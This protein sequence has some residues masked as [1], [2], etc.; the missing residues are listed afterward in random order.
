VPSRR[1]R[2]PS[3]ERASDGGSYDL[4]TR[5]RILV[6]GNST[7]IRVIPRRTSRAQGLYSERLERRLRARGIDVEVRN[8]GYAWHRV[9][10]VLPRQFPSLAHYCPDVVILNYGAG[11]A[12]PNFPPT[13]FMRWHT[14]WNSMPPLG[15]VTGRLYRAFQAPIGKAISR[16]RR[17]LYPR[18]GLRTWR[19]HP[20]RF[21]AELDRLIRVIR[22]ATGGL[23]VVLTITPATARSERGMPRLGERYRVIDDRIRNV[24]AR[25]DNPNVI[26]IDV[27][28]AIAHLDLTS[29]VTDGLHLSAEGHDAVASKLEEVVVGWIASGALDERPG[30]AAVRPADEG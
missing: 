8:D 16:S 11:E 9:H 21:E 23:V 12:Q 27:A 20:D 2:D 10:E 30:L 3:Q 13:S 18:L 29:T 22:G 15:K 6:K 25:H 14:R 28:G 7:T 26:L 19:L 17:R 24:V 4:P 5:V 1:T